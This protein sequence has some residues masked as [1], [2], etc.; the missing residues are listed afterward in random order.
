[1]NNYKQFLVKAIKFGVVG[2]SGLVIDY[3]LTYLFKEVFFTDKYIAN[4]I[5]F[6]TAALSNFILN[7]IWTFKSKNPNVLKE[8]ALFISIASI[9]LILNNLIIWFL[10]DY[11][12]LFEFYIS[13]FIAIVAVFIWNYLINY[14]FNFKG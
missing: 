6:A 3:S 1:M 5:G 11:L 4:S 12:N 10:D 13:K 14:F 2:F 7:K 8:F 9:G